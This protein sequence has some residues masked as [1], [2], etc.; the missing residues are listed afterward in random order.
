MIY[1]AT[2]TARTVDS[3]CKSKSPTFPAGGEARGRGEEGMKR[4]LSEARAEVSLTGSGI[5]LARQK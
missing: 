3:R 1:T 2:H 5:E 4:E